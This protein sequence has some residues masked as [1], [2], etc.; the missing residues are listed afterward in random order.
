MA[1]GRLQGEVRAGIAQVHA[2]VRRP[3]W[4]QQRDHA[5]PR[6]ATTA[7]RRRQWRGAANA[8]RLLSAAGG[9]ADDV[10]GE[11][12]PRVC[13]RSQPQRT[14]ARLCPAA[15]KCHKTNRISRRKEA[16]TMLRHDSNLP[17]IASVASVC[18]T[19]YSASRI[20]LP[21]GRRFLKFTATYN[22]SQ[23]NT[24]YCSFSQSHCL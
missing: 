15:L 7:I 12:R 3:I 24:N 17:D 11:I 21:G 20:F 10:P 16:T 23:R 1:G 22:K 9:P 4:G 6:S 13:R 14:H 19:F 8:H 18:G 5:S 2:P